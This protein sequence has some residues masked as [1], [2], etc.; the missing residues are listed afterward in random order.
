ME[1]KINK[2]GT[3]LLCSAKDNI[4]SEMILEILAQN[5]IYGIYKEKNFGGYTN[6]YMGYSAYG[7]D[8][9]VNSDDYEE[10]FEIVTAFFGKSCE[11]LE[12]QEEKE[13]DHP[14]K[15]RSV[16]VIV[17]V[18]VIIAVIAIAFGIRNIP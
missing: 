6:V 13:K 10:A 4:E 11:A 7:R 2:D 18:C 3:V 15:P 8:I 17:A 12:T 14:Q 1:K 5:N 9:F 16:I